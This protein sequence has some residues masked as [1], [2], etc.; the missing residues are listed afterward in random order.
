[1]PL[2]SIILP[3]YNVEKYIARALES[4]INQT[5][6][7]IEII[8]VDDKG[9]DR[10]IDIA[11]EYASRDYRIR[12]IHNEEN[13]KLLHARAEGVKVATSELIMFLDPDDEL[14]P[15]ACEIVYNNFDKNC[16]VLRFGYNLIGFDDSFKLNHP[17]DYD[18]FIKRIKKLE[19]FDF[20]MWDMAI[21]K[22]KY[23]ECFKYIQEYDLTNI[24]IAE[25]VVF[26]FILNAICGCYKKITFTLYKYYKNNTSMTNIKTLN[27]LEVSIKTKQEIIVFFNYLFCKY[28]NIFK[29][30]LY[31][32]HDFFIKKVIMEEK[33]LVQNMNTSLVNK[34]INKIKYKLEIKRLRY[35]QK[36][37]LN[38]G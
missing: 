31:Y 8:V 26:N 14:E 32:S 35:L 6:K 16:E 21:K 37:Y 1:M 4:C 34:L 12:I 15:N 5:L 22:Q 3:T 30:D 25:D 29:K 36:K 38:K 20:L 13:L 28:P 11:Y 19:Y 9:Q 27:S 23:L 33:L 2:I 7:D 24:N 18:D 10:S 17:K